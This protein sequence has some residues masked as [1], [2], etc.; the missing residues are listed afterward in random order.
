[1]IVRLMMKARQNTPYWGSIHLRLLRDR[2]NW[3][4]KNAPGKPGAFLFGER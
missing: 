3:H 4:K 1:V 2:V